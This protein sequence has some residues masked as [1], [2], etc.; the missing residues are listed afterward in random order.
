MT[1]DE[2]A[3]LLTPNSAALG[4]L[5]SLLE[6][7]DDEDRGEPVWETMIPLR[8]TRSD[9]QRVM[10]GNGDLATVVFWVDETGAEALAVPDP[11]IPGSPF[12]FMD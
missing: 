9:L 6:E 2:P 3:L 1:T 10:T 8:I 7:P 5:S 11:E 4:L 12:P